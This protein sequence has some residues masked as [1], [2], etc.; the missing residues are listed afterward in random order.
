[1]YPAADHEKLV[2]RWHRRI[3]QRNRD[4]RPQ[5]DTK[6]LKDGLARIRDDCRRCPDSSIRWTGPSAIAP[7]ACRWAKADAS[8]D[9]AG[10]GQRIA[11]PGKER[12]FV[13]IGREGAAVRKG[14]GGGARSFVCRPTS[15]RKNRP[16][17]RGGR[18]GAGQCRPMPL[19]PPPAG[20][21]RDEAA[22]RRSPSRSR[23]Q[24]FDVEAADFQRTPETRDSGKS[25]SAGV[26]RQE[27]E[28][29]DSNGRRAATKL[30]AGKE[31]QWRFAVTVPADAASRVLIIRVPTKSSLIT[32]SATRVTA[33]C[34]L[35]PILSRV[36]ATLAYHGVPF[37]VAEAVQT[38]ERISG[39]GTVSNPLLVG[40]AISVTV[41][42]S[43]GRRAAGIEI[44]RIHGYSSQQRERPRARH[45]CGLKLP[46]GWRS[47]PAQAAFCIRARRRGSDHGVLGQRRTSSNPPN[48][49]SPP[50]PST[51]GTTYKR[52]TSDRIS[53][54]ASLS[55]LSAGDLSRG[56]RRSEDG[57][58]PDISDS[59]PAPATM[60]PRRSR[61]WNQNVR[62]LADERI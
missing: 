56:R 61:I 27:L 60:C 25:R 24:I 23:G 12:C 53:R 57:A 42:P 41:S 2:L 44:V 31:T 48:T 9:R 19:S 54:R 40:P 32:T 20:R 6:F 30:A 58:W 37:E 3:A 10:A 15:R 52:A 33:T 34:R 62:M 39:I 55:A 47:T 5:G 43:A 28:S 7:A 16:A 35:R 46:Q 4:A 51:K 26:G 17:G 22:D 29:S 36:R 50:K 49:P 8:A 11:E 21:S 59:C 38:S 14:P 13:R 45:V 1:M 18:G